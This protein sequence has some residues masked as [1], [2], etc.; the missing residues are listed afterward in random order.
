MPR[1]L[2]LPGVGADPAFWHPAGGLLP[3]AWQKTYLGWPGLANQPPD[4]AVNSY[5]DLIA[6]TEHALTERAL[7]EHALA[8]H[9]LGDGPADLV[10]QSMGGVIAMQ[11]VLRDP[12]RIRRIVLTATSGG[13]DMGA[14][15]AG[16][17][18]PG[19]RAAHPHV[20]EWAYGWRPD[21]TDRIGRI[22]QPV[23][24]LWGDADPISPVAVGE[25]LRALLP[26]ARLHITQ[27]GDHM[28]ARDRAAE[29]APLIQAHLQA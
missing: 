5:D 19:Y 1:L 2:F 15:G 21:I 29:I 18:R 9:A 10:A 11:V 14:L 8:A 25:R 4:P 26:D 27:G 6:L 12:G 22:T 3:D 28:F 24:L 23:L 20:A 13:V 17:W 7:A 16:D